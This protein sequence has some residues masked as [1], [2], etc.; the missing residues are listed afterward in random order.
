MA[1]NKKSAAGS[2]LGKKKSAP[3]NSK[4]P[5]KK[6]IKKLDNKKVEIISDKLNKINKNFETLIEECQTALKQ[7]S[8][9]NLQSIKL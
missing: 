7:L 9:N 6:Q 4:K 5:V 8:H 3:V 1:K 2:S